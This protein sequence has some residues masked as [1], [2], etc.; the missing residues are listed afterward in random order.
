MIRSCSPAGIVRPIILLVLIGF[1]LGTAGCIE[2]FRGSDPSGK[3]ADSALAP[4]NETNISFLS[5]ELTRGIQGFVARPVKSLDRSMSG[6]VT[7]PVARTADSGTWTGPTLIAKGNEINMTEVQLQ[8]E[9][10]LPQ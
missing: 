6:S 10:L 7:I 8:T 4:G 5:E 1:M 3:P 2:P 9:T